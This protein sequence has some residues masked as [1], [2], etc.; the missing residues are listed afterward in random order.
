VS[1]EVSAVVSGIDVAQTG[2]RHAAAESEVLKSQGDSEQVHHIA[3]ATVECRWCY[4]HGSQVYSL[5][6]MCSW[7]TQN[8]CSS[9]FMNIPHLH[10]SNHC[11]AGIQAAQQHGQVGTMA[12]Y[13]RPTVALASSVQGHGNLAV[14]VHTTNVQ[15]WQLM[16]YCLYQPS[17]MRA[18]GVPAQLC[19]ALTPATLNT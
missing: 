2:E 5:Q 19:Q 11:L 14:Q 10:S 17:A 8:R 18:F 6:D 13:S 3:A 9:S 12:F 1:A 7:L 15:S 4:L 16:P